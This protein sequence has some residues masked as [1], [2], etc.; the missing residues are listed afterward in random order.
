MKGLTLY[1]FRLNL[2]L[3][4]SILPWSFEPCG[5]LHNIRPVCTVS[6]ARWAYM[7]TLHACAFELLKQLKL[8]FLITQGEP[9]LVMPPVCQRT[10]F[11]LEDKLLGM[12]LEVLYHCSFL[13]HL[14]MGEIPL[15]TR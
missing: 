6:P 7:R 2:R 9:A 5:H 4:I 15:I 10:L 11:Q 1:F 3:S 8:P 14:V 13:I 12:L